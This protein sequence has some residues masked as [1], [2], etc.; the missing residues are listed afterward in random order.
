MGDEAARF[1]LY[2]SDEDDDVRT[3]YVLGAS[4]YHIKLAGTA[5]E[6]CMSQIIEYWTSG[7]LTLNSA[8]ANKGG[9]FIAG[10]IE[11]A[12]CTSTKRGVTAAGSVFAFASR[13]ERCTQCENVVLF[14]PARRA[15]SAC[16][17][18]L[19]SY[20][21]TTSARLFRVNRRRPLR[22]RGCSSPITTSVLACFICRDYQHPLHPP[23]R[24]PAGCLHF[25]V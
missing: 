22:S 19:A 6:E 12:A 14:S 25:T 9:T 18:P 1:L 23:T 17:S 15:N 8:G 7:K 4:A 20:S 2:S 11:V 10:G 5:L 24:H 13:R 3:A 21:L 16:V